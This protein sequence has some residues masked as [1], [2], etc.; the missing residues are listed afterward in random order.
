MR[1][2]DEAAAA[3]RDA[4]R[5]DASRDEINKTRDISEYGGNGL[6]PFERNEV[7]QLQIESER[8]NELKQQR[9]SR[10]SWSRRSTLQVSVDESLAEE[11]TEIL[12]GQDAGKLAN[13][14]A[15][16]LEEH[17]EFMEVIIR[18]K[19]K[20]KNLPMKP[21]TKDEQYYILNGTI[22]AEAIEDAY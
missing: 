4:I 12:Y 6:T 16:I 21:F 8:R 9:K 15:D 18:L 1:Y 13:E 19:R 5:D 10:R 7:K 3:F 11:E 2:W 14:Y 17:P 20:Y 22:E